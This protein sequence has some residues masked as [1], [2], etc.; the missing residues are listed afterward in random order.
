ML[1]I[2]IMP[3]PH[4]RGPNGSTSCQVGRVLDRPRVDCCY[5]KSH[6]ILATLSEQPGCALHT[7][8]TPVC[9][10]LR[11]SMGG[12]PTMRCTLPCAGG[13]CP[14]FP[15][16]HA[17]GTLG[18]TPGSPGAPPPSPPPPSAPA[19]QGA[20]WGAPC[21]AASSCRGCCCSGWPPADPDD[22]AVVPVPPLSCRP[23]AP[24][25]PA[26][27]RPCE[28]PECGARGGKPSA[29][30]LASMPSSRPTMSANAG[31][32][33]ATGAQHSAMS[34]ACAGSVPG[35]M[36]GRRPCVATLRP[37][38]IAVM[39]SNGTLRARDSHITFYI[40]EGGGSKGSSGIRGE[41]C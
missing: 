13:C 19:A 17:T 40:C 18:A 27:S 14:P 20:G 3:G 11:C 15:A 8:H 32:W 36:P 16:P 34:R 30:P 25:A 21:G 12:G 26:S 31:R 1:P 41:D 38:C 5:L 29:T 2:Q 4:I 24:Y 33:S 6:V 7:P 35:G 23:L 28:L 22:P 9:V 10:I 39:P 37:A